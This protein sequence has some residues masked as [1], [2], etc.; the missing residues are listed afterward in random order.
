[1]AKPRRKPIDPGKVVKGVVKDVVQGGKEI[2][3]QGTVAAERIKE[4]ARKVRK[5]LGGK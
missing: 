4:G 1:M 3:R 5:H 2:V